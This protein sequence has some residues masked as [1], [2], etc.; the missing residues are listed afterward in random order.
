MVLVPVGCW[1][2]G[3][4]WRPEHLWRLVGLGQVEV[5]EVS[6]SVIV[7]VVGCIWLDMGGC[8]LDVEC[9]AAPGSGCPDHIGALE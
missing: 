6:G 7:V 9:P 2:A 4:L 3:N 5:D 1:Q 8:V